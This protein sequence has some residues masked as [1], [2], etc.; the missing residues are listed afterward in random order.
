MRKSSRRHRRSADWRWFAA[1]IFCLLFC[2]LCLSSLVANFSAFRAR[3]W[4]EAWD[5]LAL[6]ALAKSQTYRPDE[7]DWQEA[8]AS[9]LLAT[10]LAPFNADFRETLARVYLAKQFDLPDGDP[11]LLPSL[12]Q[13]EEQYRAA[14]ALRPNWPY[15]YLGLSYV[16]RRA[17]RLDADY[18]KSLR[19]AVHYGPWEPVVLSSVVSFNLDVLHKLSPSTREFVLDTLR[20]GQAWT[21][22]SKGNPMPYGNQI[23]RV[24]TSRHKEMLVCSW[25]R[26]D[27]PLLK[28]RCQ[29]SA[30]PKLHSTS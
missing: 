22:D 26:M 12:R 16:M 5:N 3:A 15:G 20:R 29:P 28:Q 4:V 11:R 30:L 8:Q 10:R 18:E 2:L 14:I 24:V 21:S 19:D 27:T 17:V 6:G 23:W 25:L 7:A 13:A 1:G 9:A